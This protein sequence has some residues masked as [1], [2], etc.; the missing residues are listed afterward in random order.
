MGAITVV[1][2]LL[3]QAIALF[4]AFKGNAAQAK[5]DTAL[6]SAMAVINAFTP[7]VQQFASGVEVTP[8]MVRASLDK[9]H[10]A[11]AAFDA[12]IAKQGG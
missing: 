7:L 8:A 9:Q 4:G 12:E 2:P 1:L 10:A 3:Q 11:M 5:A 6:Q